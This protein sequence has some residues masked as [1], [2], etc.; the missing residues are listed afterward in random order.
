MKRRAIAFFVA[1]GLLASVAGFGIA[2]AGRDE[3]TG[4]D[5]IQTP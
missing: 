5:S 1:L 4:P 3:A 2:W